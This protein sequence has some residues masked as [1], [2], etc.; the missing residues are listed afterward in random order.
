MKRHR[1]V[2]HFDTTKQYLIVAL[3][4][5]AWLFDSCTPLW[6]GSKR[7]ETMLELCANWRIL[8]NRQ[9]NFSNRGVYL[10]LVRERTLNMNAPRGEGGCQANA[11]NCVQGGGGCW[12]WEF[13][14]IFSP[15]IKAL[16]LL[17]IPIHW[18]L[19]QS[20][21]FRWQFYIYLSILSLK[22]T[23]VL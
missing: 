14:R 10:L 12:A 4:Q 11:V 20:A 1:P 13:E 16:S 18:I 21:A 23:L 17:S 9:I 7:K 3:L 2:C 5:V 15:V 19:G 6:D 22:L 8:W